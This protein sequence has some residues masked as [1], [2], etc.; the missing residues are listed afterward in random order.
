[1]RAKRGQKGVK[2]NQFCLVF[3]LL[4]R[5]QPDLLR[6][7][8]DLERDFFAYCSS[9]LPFVGLQT[10]RCVGLQADIFPDP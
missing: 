4:V 7:Y 2:N 8:D 5:F 9:N 6:F 1:M 3:A 10:D